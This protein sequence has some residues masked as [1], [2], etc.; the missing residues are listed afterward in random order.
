MGFQVSPHTYFS[1]RYRHTIMNGCTKFW[2]W[3]AILCACGSFL[4][5]ASQLYSSGWLNN[6]FS[7]ATYTCAGLAGASLFYE[8]GTCKLTYQKRRLFIQSTIDERTA[9]EDS[10]S[11]N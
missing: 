9:L 1:Q 4:Y 10:I 2:I 8:V 6:P 3:A 7:H 11:T 5:G